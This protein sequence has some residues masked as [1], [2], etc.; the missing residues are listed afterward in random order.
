VNNKKK[1]NY[2]QSRVPIAVD[3]T[4]EL[5]ST[6]F[7]LRSYKI[8]ALKFDLRQIKVFV[9][10]LERVFGILTQFSLP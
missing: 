9:L 8:P 6:P 1:K 3:I 2:R 7:A 10:D 4:I 5:R